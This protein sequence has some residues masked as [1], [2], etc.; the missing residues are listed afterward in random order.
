MEERGYKVTYL[1]VDKYGN[2]K[3]DQLRRSITKDTKLISIQM[4]NSE[5]GALQN[6][7]EIGSIAKKHDILFHSDAAQSF[8]KY[9]IDVD[10]MNIDLLTISGYKVGAPKGIAALYIRDT[11]RI[12]P[13]MFGSGDMFFP[14][15]KPTALI[16]SFGKSVEDFQFSKKKV[17]DNYNALVSELSKIEKVYINSRTPSH[18][19]SIAI[20]GVLLNDVFKRMNEYS[21][22]AGCSCLGQDKSN[23]IDA[24][25]PE[26]KLPSC[27]VRI[28]FSDKVE[29]DQL[30]DFARKLGQIVLQLRKEKSV[31]KGC[32]SVVDPL[33]NNIG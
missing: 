5:I 7:K 16:S 15:T 20:G 12:Q 6:M 8:C 25:D 10:D 18:I 1:D 9:D 23:V 11:S 17:I 13:I 31:G 3:I 22:S 33:N 24:I 32:Q 4:L 26:D 28:S 19:V 30:I 29:K 27:I 21:F 14:G 2:I